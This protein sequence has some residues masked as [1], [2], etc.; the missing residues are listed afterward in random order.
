MRTAGLTWGCQNLAWGPSHH[1]NVQNPPSLF[2]YTAGF[3]VTS[4]H[5]LLRNNSLTWVMLLF[6]LMSPTL[7]E[8][9]ADTFC[10]DHL[11]LAGSKPMD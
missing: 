9:Q 6:W 7:P 1:G 8:P 3:S 10:W 5:S 2:G 11:T 4:P